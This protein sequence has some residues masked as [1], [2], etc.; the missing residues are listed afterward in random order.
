MSRRRMLRVFQSTLP[1]RGATSLCPGYHLPHSTFQSTLPARG[2]TN[3]ADQRRP[4]AFDFN[5]RSPHGERRSPAFI[6]AAAPGI[7]IHAPRTGSDLNQAGQP[8][9]KE[10]FNPRSPHG[11]RPETPEETGASEI[12]SIHAP[13]TGSDLAFVRGQPH[14][15]NFNPRSPHGE[16]RQ[17]HN[18]TR[19]G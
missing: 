12:I 1:A 17:E 7:S 11:E 10:D 18:G 14:R 3:A 16:R 15:Q 6:R 9:R 4:S 2:A 13:R 19:T 5:P 8:R